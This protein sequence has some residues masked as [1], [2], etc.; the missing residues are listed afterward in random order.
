[1]AHLME[2]VEQSPTISQLLQQSTKSQ[3]CAPSLKSPITFTANMYV[4]SILSLKIAKQC[5][6]AILHV[7]KKK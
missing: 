4:K 1:M 6:F 7:D 3:I 2:E 5:L